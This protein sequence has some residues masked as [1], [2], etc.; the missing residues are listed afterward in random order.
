MQIIEKVYKWAFAL[1]VRS[2]SAIKI[3]VLHH[4]A[5]GND[6]TPDAIHQEH[7]KKKWAGIGYHFII[8]PDG[9]IYR[10]RPINTVGAAVENQNTN[11]LNICF[12]GNFNIGNNKP[13]VAQIAACLSLIDYLF[14]YL[15]RKLPVKGHRELMAT[16]CPGKNFPLKTF[17]R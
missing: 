1:T 11:T 3:I 13:T 12:I 17:Q 7:L 9:K 6:L 10:G 2:L 4:S 15:K 16:A 14:V 5:S 8:T